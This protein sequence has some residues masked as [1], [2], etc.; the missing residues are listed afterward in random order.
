[1]VIV[2]GHLVVDPE[3]REAVDAFRGSGL[4]DEQAA[5][6]LSASVTG[7]EVVSARSLT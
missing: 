1:M 5:A 6:I 2:A 3:Q 7:Y 4:D